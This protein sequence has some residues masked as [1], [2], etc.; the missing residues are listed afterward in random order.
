VGILR[1]ANVFESEIG[2][3]HI[4]VVLIEADQV[5]ELEPAQESTKNVKSLAK[6]E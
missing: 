3:I 2:F 5:P 1:E 6:P 4:F